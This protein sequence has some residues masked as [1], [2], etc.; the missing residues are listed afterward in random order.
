MK[1]GN[2]MIG[3]TNRFP[4][5]PE[6]KYKVIWHD[7]KD[8]SFTGTEYHKSLESAEQ[9]KA[10]WIDLGYSAKIVKGDFTNLYWS[11]AKYK[12]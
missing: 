4:G 11:N 12:I 10:D 5:R 7:K 8:K 6:I 2:I 1:T 9:D 3:A